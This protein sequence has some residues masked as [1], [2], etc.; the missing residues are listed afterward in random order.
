[1]KQMMCSYYYTGIQI[2]EII[3]NDVHVRFL[4]PNE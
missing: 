1:M 2:Y 4:Y 3:V